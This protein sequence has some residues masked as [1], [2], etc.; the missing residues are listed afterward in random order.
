MVV[1]REAPTL[2]VVT[3]ADSA[4]VDAEGRQTAGRTLLR[5]AF[6]RALPF[7]PQLTP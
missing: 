5:T 4:R 3:L 2:Y 6:Y 7:V 1:E